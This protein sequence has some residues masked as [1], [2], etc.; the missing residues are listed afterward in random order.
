MA[1]EITGQEF[2]NRIDELLKV[3]LQTRT[4]LNRDLGF[5]KNKLTQWKVRNIIPSADLVLKIAKYLNTSCEYLL[6][7]ENPTVNTSLF[8]SKDKAIDSFYKAQN[9]FME[10]INE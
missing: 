2:V 10:K 9:V 5:D 8:I 4:D 3:Q 6:T 1:K 7:G